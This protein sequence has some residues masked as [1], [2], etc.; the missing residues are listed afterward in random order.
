MKLNPKVSVGSYETWCLMQDL[1]NIIDCAEVVGKLKT[2][3]KNKDVVL[4]HMVYNSISDRVFDE[5]FGFNQ[6]AK[7]IRSVVLAMLGAIEW[8]LVYRH[9]L[10]HV[11]LETQEKIRYDEIGSF[12]N[13]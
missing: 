11:E 13:G 5:V 10:Y 1:H 9:L 4:M 6:K 7:S 3:K 12:D 8:K 2:I